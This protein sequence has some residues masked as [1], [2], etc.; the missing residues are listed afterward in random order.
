MYNVNVNYDC[1][2]HFECNAMYVYTTVLCSILLIGTLLGLL[3][4]ETFCLLFLETFGDSFSR[5]WKLFGTLDID[6]EN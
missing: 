5:L 6:L 2:F 3:F 4:V 1:R